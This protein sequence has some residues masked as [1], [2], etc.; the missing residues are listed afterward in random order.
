MKKFHYMEPE[1]IISIIVSLVIIAIGVYA[2]FIIIGETQD[3]WTAIEGVSE[4][5]AG[6]IQ[7]SA[8]NATWYKI[9]NSTG[10]STSTGNSVFNIIGIVLVIGAIMSIV[11]L[12]YSYVRPGGY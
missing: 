3:Q 2:F 10:N 6:S 1:M 4:P 8:D 5:V 7:S 12:I 11:G 9:M